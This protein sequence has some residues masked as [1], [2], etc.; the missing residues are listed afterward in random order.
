MEDVKEVHVIMTRRVVLGALIVLTMI[1]L[2]NLG[3]SLAYAQDIMPAED[4]TTT[5]VWEIKET[6]QVPFVSFWTGGEYWIAEESSRMTFSIGEIEDDVMGG[7]KLGN[8]TVIANDTMIA[9]DL[10]LGVWGIVEFSPG[11]FIKTASSDIENLNATAFA[12]VERVESNYL[13]GTMASYYDNYTIMSTNY[14]CIIFEYQQDPTYYGTPQRTKL[15]YSLST[16]VLLYANTSYFFGAPYSP[17]HFEI[18]FVTI[19]YSGTMPD[20][21]LIGV[22]V[23]AVVLFSIIVYY[24]KQRR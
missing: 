1:I 19:E 17:Y 15:I 16:G 11:L 23:I 20:P 9:R 22:I 12:A 21:I 13:N 18:E 6:P 10:T 2:N 8:M 5:V 14:E 24:L 7:L 3:S 4:R